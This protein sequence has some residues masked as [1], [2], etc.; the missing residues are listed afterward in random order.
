MKQRFFAYFAVFFAAIAAVPGT[1]LGADAEV[2]GFFTGG[3][4]VSDSQN[5]F[6][7]SIDRS[8]DFVSLT[9]AGIQLGAT[10]TERISA[11]VQLVAEGRQNLAITPMLDLAQVRFLVLPGQELLA[12]QLRLPLFMISDYRMVGALYPWNV[13]PP[14]VYDLLPPQ[15]AGSNE[16]FVGVDL[17]SQWAEFS[18]WTLQSE[19]YGGGSEIHLQPPGQV[20]DAT[21][22]RI[23]G[24]NVSLSTPQF[25]LRASYM[26][27]L[28]QS[29]T[30]FAGSAPV[31]SSLGTL[32]FMTLGAKWEPG[33][34]LLMSE[35]AHIA[36]EDPRFAHLYTAYGTAGY[37]LFNRV[38]LL[39][40]TVSGILGASQT[41]QNIQ[42]TS[43]NEGFNIQLAE[44]SVVLKFEVQ[45]TVLPPPPSQGG[46]G[47]PGQSQGSSQG[48]FAGTPANNVV[49]L[50]LT[51]V[52]ATF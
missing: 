43:F 22:K 25:Q 6:L 10:L 34:L 41:T 1:A 16:T 9:D 33:D 46:P 42:Q 37:Y 23:V 29:T 30:A 47:A 28:N 48:L 19:I 31:D 49:N 21:S 2:H 13:P 50:F 7:G 36:G 40:G 15:A 18:G 8:G 11:K 5:K 27:S 3:Y 17:L 4:A 12:G 45:Q 32:Q 20:I 38:L 51:S 24:A 14:E 52:S 44:G 39:H 35:F 26:N